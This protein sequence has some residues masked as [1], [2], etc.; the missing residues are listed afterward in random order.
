[1]SSV[2]FTG[3]TPSK[4]KPIKKKLLQVPVNENAWAIYMVSEG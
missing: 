2:H 1:M 3:C 4:K